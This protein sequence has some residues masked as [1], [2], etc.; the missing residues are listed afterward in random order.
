MPI[1]AFLVDMRTG[2]PLGNTESIFPV[3]NWVADTIIES[4]GV[5]SIVTW[6]SLR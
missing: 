5:A 1:E 4:V 6:L 3:S 2:L